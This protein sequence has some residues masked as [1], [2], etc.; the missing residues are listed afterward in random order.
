MLIAKLVLI[1]FLISLSDA[2]KS[3]NLE[4][5]QNIEVMLLGVKLL[6]MLQL[7]QSEVEHRKKWLFYID[8]VN[9]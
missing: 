4:S 5:A 8:L 1:L 9:T 3:V 6:K 2:L 7:R